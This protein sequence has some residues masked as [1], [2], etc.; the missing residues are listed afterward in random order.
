MGGLVVELAGVP[1][2]IKM[3]IHV[4]LLIV[5]QITNLIVDAEFKKE[6]QLYRSGQHRPEGSHELGMR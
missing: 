3:H 1:R 6:A 4:L 5:F 2:V